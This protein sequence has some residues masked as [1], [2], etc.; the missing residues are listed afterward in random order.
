MTDIIG[1]WVLPLTVVLIV[2]FGLFKKVKVFD[3]FMQGAKKGLLTVYDLLPT[4]TGIVVAV[5]M[6]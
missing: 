3:C 2:G 6:L 4:I 1:Y 5:T